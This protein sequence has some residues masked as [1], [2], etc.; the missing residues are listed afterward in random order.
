MCRAPRREGEA[1][2]PKPVY[3]PCHKHDPLEADY[4]GG[5]RTCPPSA[6][7]TSTKRRRHEAKQRPPRALPHP[8]DWFVQG[9]FFLHINLIDG[10]CQNTGTSDLTCYTVS[11]PEVKHASVVSRLATEPTPPGCTCNSPTISHLEKNS[12]LAC[13]QVRQSSGSSARISLCPLPP[14]SN[15][16][17]FL[18]EHAG[19][20]LGVSPPNP[21]GY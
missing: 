3:M 1:Q 21:I 17:C 11:P 20:R 14:S 18:L 7:S 13:L 2:G 5:L 6:C 15:A 9:I 8:P 4:A 12:S 16:A 10:R 19:P